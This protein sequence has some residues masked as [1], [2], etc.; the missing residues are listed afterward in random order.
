MI[1]DLKPDDFE[2]WSELYKAYANFYKVPMNTKILDSVW[3]W[4]HDKNHVVRGICYEF[5]GKIVGIAHYRSMPRPLKGQYVGF[6]DDLFVEPNYRSQKIGR[7]LIEYLKFLSKANNWCGIRWTTHSSNKNA[8]KLY[9]KIANN[10]GFDLYEIK[11][12]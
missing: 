8:K 1:R 4:L 2:N 7:K 5:E 9:D 10:T 12:D 6:L 11:G 3:G